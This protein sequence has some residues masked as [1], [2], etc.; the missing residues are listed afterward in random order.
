MRLQPLAIALF[1]GLESWLGWIVLLLIVGVLL[2]ICLA[3]LALPIVFY[4]KGELHARRLRKS[5][6][7][8]A[9][10]RPGRV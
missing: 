2:L 6:E 7:A 8:G 4:V 9:N 10:P 3:A 1:H 5:G